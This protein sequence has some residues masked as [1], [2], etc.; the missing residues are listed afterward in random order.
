[1]FEPSD[2][3][4]RAVEDIRERVG[5]GKAI[6]ALS[7][8]VDSSV[9][10]V[11]ASK[12]IG[13]RLVAVFVDH[14]LLRE[15][16]VDYV[17][18]TFSSRLNL[19]FIDASE[20]FL[21]ELRGVT[22]PEEKRRIIGRVFI[23]VFEEVAEEIGAEYLVQGTIA[24][25]WIESEGKIKS[26]HNVTLPHG[27]VLKIVEPLRELYKDEVRI[28]ARELGLPDKIIKR[29]PFPGP[30][31]A[32]RIIGEITPEKIRICRK[33]NAIVEEEVIGAGLDERLWQYFA[34]LT[35]TM[36]TGVK[37][38]MRDFGYLVV[39]RMVESIDA[40]TARVPELPWDLI[41][42]ISKRITSEI[43]EVTHVALSVSDKP[44]STIEFA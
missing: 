2:F 4:K 44:P 40:M 43:P 7:G 36:A 11:L 39:L 14:G 42:R 27:L 22:D 41:R 37:G 32:V 28:L 21:E 3:I 23:E 6:I 18:E 33:A 17:K 9:A 1:M 13:D 20:R 5:D 16:E 19:R 8:G 31:L 24:P 10:S 35:D 12:A 25:D 34:V 38:D 26:H 30:G 15:G 29:Q